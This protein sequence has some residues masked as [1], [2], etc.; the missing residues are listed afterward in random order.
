MEY[1]KRNPGI[2][3]KLISFANDNDMYLRGHVL[4]WDGVRNEDLKNIVGNEENLQQGTMAYLYKQYIDGKITEEQADEI[5]LNIQ[6]KLEDYVYNHIKELINKYPDVKEWD[7]VNEPNTSHYFQ[8]YLYNKECYNNNT[9]LK[10]TKKGGNTYSG[11]EEYSKFLGECFNKAR[12]ANANLKLVLNDYYISGTSQYTDRMIDTVNKI[13]KYTDNIDAIGV[14]YHNKNSSISTP[15][16]YYNEINK[17]L[18]RTGV[19]EAVITEYDNYFGEKPKNDQEKAI[20]AD[21]LKDTLISV[22]SNKNISEFIFWVYNGDKIVDEERREYEKL[23]EKWLND[24]QI[25]NIDEKNNVYS[26]RA[27]NGEYNVTVTLG[28]RTAEASLQVNDNENKVEIIIENEIEG[29]SIKSKPDKIEYIQNNEELN[30]TGGI[31]QVLYNDGTVKEISMNSAD[32]IISGFDNKELGYKTIEVEYKGKKATFEVEVIDKTPPIVQVSYSTK[33]P[34]NGVVTATIKVNEKVQQIEGWTIDSTKTILTKIYTKNE[35][36]TVTITDLSGNTNTI[37]VRVENIDKTEIEANVKY[38]TTLLTNKDVTV[39]IIL[40]KKV[41]EVKGWSLSEDGTQIYKTFT[42]NGEEE[43][44]LKDLAGNTKMV[45]INV[46]N[47]DKIAP[48]AEVSY[49]ITFATNKDVIATITANEEIQKIEGWNLQKDGKTLTK[50][51]KLN[52]EETVT[53]TDLAGNT[54]DINIKITNIDKDAPKVQLNYSTTESTTED[55]VVT[56]ISNKEMKE[57]NGW[58]L[59]SDKKSMTKIYSENTTETIIIMDLLGNSTDAEILIS[60]INKVTDKE[61]NSNN[62][63]KTSKYTL[64]AQSTYLNAAKGILPQTGKSKNIILIIIIMFISL[65]VVFYIKIKKYRDIK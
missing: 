21:Y 11:N 36:E 22:Y 54:L 45:K 9:F 6:K 40:N 28:D 50:T 29:I 61:S 48:M 19:K 4:W 47:I 58:K 17:L 1:F 23:M 43:I 14:Q 15:Q 64:N 60:N 7:V 35:K 38:S 34:T 5:R 13:K 20:M 46:A 53:V 41:L 2:V 10:D 44:K 52:N 30:L 8:D 65:A 56:I 49:D 12:E 37:E 33:E 32:V 51:Y 63:S 55:V 26:G 31:I 59:S 62:V 18:N 27:Y 16:G 3:S 42:V 39:T 24:N 25:L 57:I